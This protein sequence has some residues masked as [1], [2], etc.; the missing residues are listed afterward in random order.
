ME[1]VTQP[2]GQPD[3]ELADGFPVPILWQRCTRERLTEL[4]FQLRYL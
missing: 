3:Q 1:F 2:Q 4:G